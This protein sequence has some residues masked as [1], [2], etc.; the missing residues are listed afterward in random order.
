MN[1]W[2][3]VYMLGA[4]VTAGLGAYAAI[5]GLINAFKDP[6]L[7]ADSYNSPLDLSDASS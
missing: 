4:L 5:Q 7:N 3:V 6:Q 1:M 2:N